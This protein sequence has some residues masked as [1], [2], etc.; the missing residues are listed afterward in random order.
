MKDEG[1]N[2][3]TMIIVQKLISSYEILGLEESF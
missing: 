1:S 3:G 2:L